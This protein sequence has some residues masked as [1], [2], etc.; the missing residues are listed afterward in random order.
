MEFMMKKLL[1]TLYVTT[2]GA[3]LF[4]DRESIIIK[5][6]GEIKLRLPIHTIT[7][8]VCIGNQIYISPQLMGFCAEKNVLISFLNQYGKF[9]AR[10]CGPVSGN[11]LLR[12]E[13]YRWAD[14]EATTLLISKQFI[15]AKV[16]NTNVV[17]KRFLRDHD[18]ARESVQKA[19]TSLQ[20]N[21][22]KIININNIDSLRG[23]EGESAQVYFSVFDQLITQQKTAF[24][25]NKRNRR[26]PMDNVNAMLSFLYSILANDVIAALET[27]G[28]D[29]CVGFLHK[30]RPGRPSLALDIMEEFRPILADRIVLSMINLKKVNK[31]G[32]K[33]TETGSVIMNDATRKMVLKTYQERKKDKI[34][35]PY[36]NEEIEFGLMP[37][38]QALVMA[39]FIR[40]DIDLYPPFLWK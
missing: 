38:I 5:V 31:N 17:L 9:Y 27:V 40:K 4:K 19:V 24:K 34:R 18:S 33:K 26:P 32:F 8:I 36:L 6:D 39:R 2:E 30:D 25:F 37:Y 13:Q 28:L 21:I 35:H 14:N 11:V 10:V 29:P 1:N 20:K 23:L 12:R 16:F 3:G 15:I 7:S 22:R